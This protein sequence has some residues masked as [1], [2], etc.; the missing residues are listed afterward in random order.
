M[1]PVIQEFFDV[2]SN[3]YSYVVSCPETRKAAVIDPVLNF[4]AA[5]GRTNTQGADKVIAYLD[6]RF[7]G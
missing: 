5:A 4:E 3:T 7:A 1:S 2:D 6:Q